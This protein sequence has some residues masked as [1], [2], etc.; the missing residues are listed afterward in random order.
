[1]FGLKKNPELPPPP[2]RLN[3]G[4]GKCFHP[5]WVNVD[6]APANSHVLQHDL[7]KPLPFPSASCAVVYHSHLLE[8]LSR[9]AGREFMAE[10]HRLLQPGGILRVV[11]PDLETIARLY[12]QNLDAALAGDTQA[13]LRH[14]WMTLELLDQLVR[15][16]S[17]GE[18]GRYWRQNPMPAEEFV[19]Q[20]MGWE[21][22][23]LLQAHRAP[24]TAATKANKPPT[25]AQ[26]AAFRQA[27]EMHQWMYDRI[28]LR[29]LLETTGFRQC[30]VCR[31]SESAI[32]NFNSYLLDLTKEGAVRKP[33]SLFM[34]ARKS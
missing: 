23:S 19:L 8:H 13:S 22:A 18:M 14:E 20:R 29:R 10:C 7:R 15:E 25:P 24:S 12:L 16:E 30:Q 1:M 26:I 11:V 3:L 6:F 5:E 28:S 27:G 33:D 32:P 2:W 4:C 31:A 9:A 17:G 21:L 34:E